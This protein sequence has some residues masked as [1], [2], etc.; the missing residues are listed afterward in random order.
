MPI[1]D[2]TYRQVALE[3]PEGH[4][5]LDCGRLRRKP[6]MTSEHYHVA[7]RL[8]MRLGRQLNEDQFELATDNGRLRTSSGR[9]F[10]PD[11]CV[12]PVDA[13][14]R[15]MDRSGKL[16]VFDEPMPLVAEVWSPSTGEYDV[17]TKF[18]E[19]RRRG[20]LEIWF[21]HPYERTLVA[22]R[23][24]PD[25]SYTETLYRG[26]TVEPVALPGVSIDLDTLFD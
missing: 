4:W 26:G 9:Y 11:L 6:D 22:W 12:I 10:V 25:T 3:D 17:E 16:E 19:Y 20:D 18:A 13:V 7:R 5:E 23:R 14:R 21:I 8:A 1:S 2:R 24:Q 15:R